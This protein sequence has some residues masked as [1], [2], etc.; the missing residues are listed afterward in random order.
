MLVKGMHIELGILLLFYSV[1]IIV[2]LLTCNRKIV[3]IVASFPNSSKES[4]T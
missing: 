2:G 3:G 4:C 1:V